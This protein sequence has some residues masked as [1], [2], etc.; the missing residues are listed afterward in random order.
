MGEW[1]EM[2]YKQECE[3]FFANNLFVM[4]AYGCY[5]VSHLAEVLRQAIENEQ[6]LLQEIKIP[7]KELQIDMV[8][9]C[10]SLYPYVISRD[11]TDSKFTIRIS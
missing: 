2:S 6:P 9:N 1:I 8:S 7:S 11:E 10:S 4:Y 5:S 3:R